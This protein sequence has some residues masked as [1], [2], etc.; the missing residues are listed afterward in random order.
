MAKGDF[1]EMTDVIVFVK[2]RGTRNK[3]C[4]HI[5]QAPRET[6]AISQH[7]KFDSV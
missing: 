2:G 1:T 3:F 7:W 6:L 4:S 5:F